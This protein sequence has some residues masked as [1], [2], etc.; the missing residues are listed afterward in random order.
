MNNPS[1]I[2]HRDA[3]YAAYDV[4]AVARA[5]LARATAALARAEAAT[6]TAEAAEAAAYDALVAYVAYAN[7]ADA[8]ADAMAEAAADAN[9]D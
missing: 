9:R 3:Y 7:D 4:A 6:A 1:T 2:C 5:A 8:A